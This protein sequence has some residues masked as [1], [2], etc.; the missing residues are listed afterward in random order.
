MHRFRR[1]RRASWPVLG[2]CALTLAL[3]AC[4]D[5]AQSASSPTPPSPVTPDA[6]PSTPA[7]TDAALPPSSP[8]DAAIAVV[9]ATPPPGDVPTVFELEP[10]APRLARLTRL[11]YRN[12]VRDLFGPDVPPPSALEPDVAADGL[13]AVGATV[14]S[15]S[16]RGV[17]QAIEAARG[18]ARDLMS[19]PEKRA[20]IYTCAPASADDAVCLGA[21]VDAWGPRLWRRPLLAEERE[22]LVA[23]GRAAGATLGTFEAGV[24]ATLARLLQS[25]FFLYR[26]EVGEPDPEVEGG[27]RL[28]SHELAARLAAFVWNSVPDDALRASADSGVLSTAEGLSAELDRMLASPKVHD[29]V[30]NFFAEWLDLYAL[31]GLNKD[32]NIFRHYSADLGAAA[33]EETLR[34]VEHLVFDL[35]ADIRTLLTTRTTFVNRR[36]AA[37]Y[38]VPATADEGFGRVELP[39]DGPRSGFLGHVAF[40]A[41][42]AHPTSTSATLRGIFVRER[43]LCQTM[44]PPPTN[45]NTAIPEPSEGAR[46]LKERLLRH[47]E[48]DF[49]AGCH[50]LTDP[51]GFGLEN[52]DGLGRWRL[53]E[54]DAQIDPAG[55]LDGASFA[56][57]AEL[58]RIISEHPSFP[59]CVTQTLFAYATGHTPGPSQWAQLDVLTAKFRA[60]GHRILTLMRDVASSP[61]FRRVG[62]VE[63]APPA[64][65]A[66]P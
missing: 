25:P 13:V 30:R 3:V 52:F 11:Q 35:D 20:R 1:R 48:D 39:A 47:M 53:E 50:A 63:A 57:S 62:P 60:R 36:L 8:P 19:T 6:A 33:R 16:P 49:C 10:P 14:A 22:G 9:D 4:D 2:L 17:E 29:A 12:A 43:L 59:G 5:G 37:I 38:N 15:L 64:E 45:L 40:L 26:V 34:L 7:A 32:P 24:E 42:N 61:G 58:K 18:L 55:E 28:T 46:T 31:D 56:D 51:V 66:Q 54:N 21:V 41:Q 27:R 44:P 23:V 65:G